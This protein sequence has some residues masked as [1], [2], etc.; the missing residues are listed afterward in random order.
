M[1]YGNTISGGVFNISMASSQGAM[2][3]P[4]SETPKKKFRPV[5]CRQRKQLREHFEKPLRFLLFPI[6]VITSNK[7]LWFASSLTFGFQRF[8]RSLPLLHW[9]KATIS[10]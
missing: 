10:L 2:G 3:S 4:E 7:V 6:A 5:M 9:T 1:F 8:S